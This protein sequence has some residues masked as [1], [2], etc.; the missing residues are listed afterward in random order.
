MTGPFTAHSETGTISGTI[1]PNGS[2]AF[3]ATFSNGTDTIFGAFTESNGTLNGSNLTEQG[4]E[5]QGLSITVTLL[6]Q[7]LRRE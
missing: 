1:S 4:L 5:N 2:F 3:T 6:S 7:T